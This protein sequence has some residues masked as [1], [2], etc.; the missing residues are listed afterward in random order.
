M[1]IKDKELI[2]T[3][4]FQRYYVFLAIFKVLNT[5]VK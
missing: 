2:N 3:V 4:V 5:I 1:L